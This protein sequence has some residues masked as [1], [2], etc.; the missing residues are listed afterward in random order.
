M[1]KGLCRV[2]RPKRGTC[3][4]QHV[5]HGIDGRF[6]VFPFFVAFGIIDGW[7][8]DVVGHAAGCHPL[9]FGCAGRDD[10]KL[11]RIIAG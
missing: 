1:P 7:G 10:L 2:V 4:R 8:L 9:K 3:R 6:V 5:Q 11:T